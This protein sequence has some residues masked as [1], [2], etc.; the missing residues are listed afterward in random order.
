[1]TGYRVLREP[2]YETLQIRGLE[3][4]VTRWGPE[5]AAGEA[6]VFLLH[7]WLDTGT[8]F[9]FLVDAFVRDR[10]LLAIDW[11]GFGRSGWPQDGYWFPDYL[12]DLEALLDALSPAAPARL[13]G[14]SMGGNVASLYAGA[15]PER[16]R[17][18]ANLEG[19]GMPRTQPAQ[20]PGRVRQWLDELRNFPAPRDYDSFET[21]GSAIR[22]RHP[23]I[24]PERADFIARQWA[25][26]DPAG[27]VQLLG[28]PRHRR[29]N[30]V[31]Y[32]REDS[33]ALWREI[34]APMLLILGEESELLARLGTDGTPRALKAAMPTAE[35]VTV[36]GAGHMLQFEQPERVAALVEDFLEAH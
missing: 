11:R 12:G 34:T 35:I 29:V 4:R 9:Q 31:L 18:I 28:D 1:M 33:E 36:A 20:G 24:A 16:V 22:R 30:P 13:L 6:P 14:H 5:P 25:Q 3:I 32:R 2:R 26:Q 17:C 8:S 27:R 19:F 10:P 7:G 21:L 23:R 15:R